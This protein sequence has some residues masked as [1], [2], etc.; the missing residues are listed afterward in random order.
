MHHDSVSVVPTICGDVA[1]SFN[2]S[3]NLAAL[4]IQAAGW[5]AVYTFTAK[6]A[7]I[8]QCDGRAT[9]SDGYYVLARN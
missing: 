7:G 9:A 3:R 8:C 5:F 2:S 4:R 6:S 1:D